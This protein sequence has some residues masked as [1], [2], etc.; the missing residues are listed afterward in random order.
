MD[1][2]PYDLPDNV[3]SQH[4]QAILGVGRAQL[5]RIRKGKAGFPSPD[6]ALSTPRRPIWLR[7]AVLR[8]LVAAGHQPAA[9]LPAFDAPPSGPTTQRWQFDRIEFV[10]IATDSERS[11]VV[12]IRYKPLASRDPRTLTICVP[13][14][15]GLEKTLWI[16]AYMDPSIAE[17]L[18]YHANGLRGAI[19]FIEP[20][21]RGDYPRIR[22]ANLPDDP[23][24][25]AT[26][27]GHTPF[28]VRTLHAPMV[29]AL[30]GHPLPLWPTGA[31]SKE[32]AA[33]WRPD[34]LD[35]PQQVNAGIPPALTSA[36]HLRIQCRVVLDQIRDG[37]RT[38]PDP[39]PAELA[40]LGNTA[41]DTELRHVFGCTDFDAGTSHSV[42]GWTPAVN[43]PQASSDETD[44]LLPVQPPATDLFHALEW[45]VAQEDLPEDM[46]RYPIGYF[47]YPD[48]IKVATVSLTALPDE[49]RRLLDHALVDIESRPNWLHTA[50]SEAAHTT[51]AHD[52]TVCNPKGWAADP[53][54]DTHPALRC[55]DELHF[56]V[57]RTLLPIGDP[58]T[59]HILGQGDERHRTYTGFI[60]DRLGRISPIPLVP[61]SINKLADTLAAI[62][63]GID[64]P[65]HLGGTPKVFGGPARLHQMMEAMSTTDHLPINWATLTE[66]VGQPPAAEDEY[67]LLRIVGEYRYQWGV[68]AE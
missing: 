54:P 44:P 24:S 67:E 28:E 2:D 59:V 51:A 16:G 68:N 56:H 50:L 34:P 49:L 1:M 13:V 32:A 43:A 66:L 8:W 55:G 31:V 23:H 4:M 48:S 41:W 33:Q 29:A 5:S 36:H 60:V 38:V 3:T 15:E 45:L 7:A 46:A 37:H 65:V 14:G 39:I 52:S 61:N 64:T 22:G 30:V 21:A 40:H 25:A 12:A 35:A 20:T 11:E 27:R 42:D 18:G 63:L 10:Q 57:P 17:A 6:P 58:V 26:E 53:A 62:V 9:V 19:A 47:G